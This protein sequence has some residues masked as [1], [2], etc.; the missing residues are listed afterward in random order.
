MAYTQS[1]KASSLPAKG[2]LCSL[3]SFPVLLKGQ[4]L[5]VEIPQ[6]KESRSCPSEHM[7][8]IKEDM[9]I[10]FAKHVWSYKLTSLKPFK[11]CLKGILVF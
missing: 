10:A 1:S 4:I 9:F 7:E 5:K 11:P 6:S 3:P 2:A 8:K